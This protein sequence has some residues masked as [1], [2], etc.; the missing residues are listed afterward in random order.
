[1]TVHQPVDVVVVGA[2]A[3]GSAIASALTRQ[4]ATV[5]LV[6]SRSDVGAGT[7]KANTAIWHTGFDAKP[8]TLEAR[9]VA[10]GHRLLEERAEEFGWPI[11]RTG[12]VLVAWDDDQ[13][14][15][16]DAIIAN[17]KANGYEHARPLSTAEVYAGDPHLG[18]GA[19]GG[20]SIPDEG[21]LDPWTIS[22]AL[23]TDAVV[24][25]ARLLL[26]SP[27]ERLTRTPTGYDVRMPT[28]SLSC[29]WVVN[30]AGLGSD[31]VDRAA[32]HEGFT[33]TPRRGQ[34]I[35]YDKSARPLVNHVILPVPTATTK[36]VLVA[37][38]VYGNVLLGP[39]AE[40][41]HDRSATQTTADGLDFLLGR[42]RRILPDLLD[43]E[44]TATYSGL[45]AATEHADYC[46]EV[47]DNYVRVAGIRST[48]ISSSLAIAEQV[49]GDLAEAGLAMR[50]LAHPRTVRMPNLAESRPRP[51]MDAALITRDPAYGDLVCL[52]ER[53][54]AGEIRDAVASDIPARDVDG[55][56]R[57][58][59][60]LAGRCQGFHCG[61]RITTTLAGAP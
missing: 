35:V 42:G 33:I 21:L 5:A 10:R 23:A 50:P 14:A 18:P 13:F 54:S 60:A 48:G 29:T 2:G 32:G 55:L 41:L 49:V 31:V 45:R 38:T 15:R 3:V 52:C 44:I 58:T 6:E 11:E 56:R 37:P 24:N 46:Y 1:M 39:T 51:Y 59:R 34:L 36:G 27:V 40:D 20:V 30:A 8:G 43:Q 57:R 9:L 7:S 12:A 22:I 61:A 19:R 26:D 53:V 4:G 17:A 47:F 28:G 16:L 25:G